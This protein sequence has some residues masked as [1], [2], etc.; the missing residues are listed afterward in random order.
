MKYSIIM[1]STFALLA[2][3]YFTS[4]NTSGTQLKNSEY[5]VTEAKKDLSDANAEYLE[6]LKKYRAD[7]DIQIEKN[8]DS[9]K[10][11][12][13]RVSS[14]KKE[15]QVGY[16]LKIAELEKKNTEM[17]KKLDQYSGKSADQW[18]S[19]KTEFNR[20][21]KNLGDAFRDMTAN[22]VR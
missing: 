10:E 4:C 1:I 16:E 22:N 18:E 6:D 20:D 8:K 12:K 19:F 14:E 9:I 11:F 5:K 2:A 13:A 17:K 21:M 7:A 15:A 3:A